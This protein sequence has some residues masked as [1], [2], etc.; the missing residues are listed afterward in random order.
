MPLPTPLAPL[1]ASVSSASVLP[2]VFVGRPPSTTAQHRQAS[3]SAS[4]STSAP[5][6]APAA[7]PAS[8]AAAAAAAARPHHA[9]RLTF[10]RFPLLRKG[11]RELTRS[12]SAHSNKGSNAAPPAPT[13]SLFLAP[14]ASLSKSR[15]LDTPPA[16][17]PTPDGHE[18]LVSEEVDSDTTA[19]DSPRA[20][21]PDKMHQ[22]SSRLLRMTDDERPYT[23]VG[24]SPQSL[25]QLPPWASRDRPAEDGMREMARFP[26]GTRSFATRTAHGI[27]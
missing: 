5:A 20:G 15:G 8:T 3:P 1:T 12:P 14:R 21:R 9:R 18:L 6:D 7:A 2:A 10:S 17:K 24:D 13:H 4:A 16:S 22:T 19:A 23:R 27:S 11:S 26:T 25:P